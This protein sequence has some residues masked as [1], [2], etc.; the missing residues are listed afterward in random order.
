MGLESD[1]LAWVDMRF[2]VATSLVILGGCATPMDEP[3]DASS[4]RTDDVVVDVSQGGEGPPCALDIDCQN[5]GTDCIKASCVD[6]HCT[7]T[8][9]G[10]GTSCYDGPVCTMGNACMDGVCTG[11]GPKDCSGISGECVEGVCDPDAGGI[12]RQRQR[13]DGHLCMCGD[14]GPCTGKC[15]LGFCVGSGGGG[16]GDAGPG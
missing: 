11:G 8:K 3:I 6:K 15:S 13:P 4:E 5:L 10:N 14:G 9:Q 12:C 2:A 7:L 1:T 16:I